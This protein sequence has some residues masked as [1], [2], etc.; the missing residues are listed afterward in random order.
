[1]WHTVWNISSLDAFFLNA[2]H[3]NAL[4]NTQKSRWN[5]IAI[6]NHQITWRAVFS[7]YH[8]KFVFA[9]KNILWLMRR[10]SGSASFRSNLSVRSAVVGKNVRTHRVC[11]HNTGLTKSSWNLSDVTVNVLFVIQI[12][13]VLCWPWN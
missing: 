8:R 6:A 11:F 7:C 3:E 12:D 13:T 5:Q 9:T 2:P 10:Q 4:N 1:M